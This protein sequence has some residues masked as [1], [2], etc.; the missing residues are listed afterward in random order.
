MSR[1]ICAGQKEDNK[2]STSHKGE[3]SSW[4][5]ASPSLLLESGAQHAL[6]TVSLQSPVL[7]R[8]ITQSQAQDITGEWTLRSLKNHCVVHLKLC[9][10]VGQL[11]V[12]KKIKIK[13]PL[14]L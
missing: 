2:L 1:P 11:Q 5:H 10:I 12:N 3:G 6:P 13:K 4:P 14:I 9:Y 8:G 7:A